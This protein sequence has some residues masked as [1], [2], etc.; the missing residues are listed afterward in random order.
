MLI[1]LYDI[2]EITHNK[3]KATMAVTALLLWA[4]NRI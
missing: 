2:R 3:K 4:I 1:N